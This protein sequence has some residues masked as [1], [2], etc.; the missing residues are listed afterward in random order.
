MIQPKNTDA[1]ISSFPPEIQ[2]ILKEVRAVVK[3]AAPKSEEVISYGMPGYKQNGMLVWYG[4]HSKHIGFYPGASGISAFKKEISI[5]KNAKGSVQ[6]PFEKP[7]PV[8]LITR[9]VKFKIS[10]N[11]EKAKKKK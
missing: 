11:Q 7:L 4:A 9:M 1:Y 6:F 5:Y 3:K 8:A 10:E 2:K